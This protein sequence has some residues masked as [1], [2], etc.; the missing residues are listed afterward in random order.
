MAKRTTTW[1]IAL[2]TSFTSLPGAVAPGTI[3]NVTTLGESAI[4]SKYR[5]GTLIRIVGDI[6]VV[7]TAGTPVVSFVIWFAGAYSG[8]TF[9]IDW[10]FDELER[11]NVLMSWMSAV[12][13]SMQTWRIAVDVRSKRKLGAG[14]SLQL[15]VQNHSAATNDCSFAYTL[16][17]LILM[18]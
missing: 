14:V 7:R 1:D 2:D 3:V 6:V 17:H 16:K 10:G 5:G 18:P 4:E 15:A 11:N 12:E 9:P 8:F 13:T